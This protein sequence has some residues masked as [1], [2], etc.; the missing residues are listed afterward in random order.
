[1]VRVTQDL[2]LGT[3]V[4]ACSCEHGNEDS[5][6]IEGGG[7]LDHLSDCEHCQEGLHFVEKVS[8]LSTLYSTIC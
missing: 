2:R 6:T 5:V 4:V 8:V 7:F 1:M 3:M